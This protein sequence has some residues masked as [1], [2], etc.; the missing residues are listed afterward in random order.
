[1]YVFFGNSIPCVWGFF[2]VVGELVYVLALKERHAEL[3]CLEKV[4]VSCH[5]ESLERLQFPGWFAKFWK[6]NGVEPIIRFFISHM[7]PGRLPSG[8]YTKMDRFAAA[9]IRWVEIGNEPNIAVEWHDEGLRDLPHAGDAAV[10]G[11]SDAAVARVSEDW[12]LDA[13]ETIRHGCWPAY[14]ALSPTDWHNGINPFYSSVDFYRRSFRYYAAD[15]GRAA[16][17]RKVFADGAW[18]SVHT[19]WRQPGSLALDLDPF[20]GFPSLNSGTLDNPWD[21][22]LRG[23]EIPLRYL[24]ENLGMTGVKVIST[25]GGA[26][27]PEHLRDHIHDPMYSEDEWANCLLAVYDWLAKHSDMVAMCPWVLTDAY[28]AE[29]SWP[30]NGWYRGKSPRS[31]I[32]K[33]RQAWAAV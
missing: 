26:F 4:A 5:V 2:P 16:R 15:P 28:G 13:E 27:S 32:P 12:L 9:G 19:S 31:I 1:M 21:I 11:S 14:P 29:S 17:F 33:L 8:I 6:D 30:E 22:C 3:S 18:L 25:E 23:Y 10:I 20:T 7:Y 24:K